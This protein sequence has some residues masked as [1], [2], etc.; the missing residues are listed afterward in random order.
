MGFAVSNPSHGRPSCSAR[1]IGSHRLRP[2]LPRRR[3]PAIGNAEPVPDVDRGNRRTKIG[4]F[5]FWELRTHLGVDFIA[6]TLRHQG[7][8]LGPGQCRALAA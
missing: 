6:D 8:R 4:Q 7:Q 5:L 1:K 3:S 2:L